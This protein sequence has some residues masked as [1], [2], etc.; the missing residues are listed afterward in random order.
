ML[1][2]SEVRKYSLPYLFSI[3]YNFRYPFKHEKNLI[4]GWFQICRFAE[5]FTIISGR[6][7]FKQY[8]LYGLDVRNFILI[9]PIEIKEAAIIDGCSKFSV[10][11]GI[12]IPAMCPSIIAVSIFALTSSRNLRVFPHGI[13]AFLGTWSTYRGGLTAAGILTVVPLVCLFLIFQMCFISGIF[14]KQLK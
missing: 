6:K 9:N 5:F 11:F 14:S 13:L 2:H 10:L 4:V 7:V 3:S 12:A 1:G 8:P